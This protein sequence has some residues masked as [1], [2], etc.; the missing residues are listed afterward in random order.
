[1]GN[2]TD[3]F[4]DKPRVRIL[5]A[6]VQLDGMEFTRADLAEEAGLSKSSAN[7]AFEGL[8]QLDLVDQVVESKH[9]VF[10]PRSDSGLFRILSHL[11]AATGLALRNPRSGPVEQD[12]AHAL[13]DRFREAFAPPTTHG[14]SNAGRHTLRIKVTDRLHTDDQTTSSEATRIFHRW[15][16]LE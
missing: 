4:G 14:W 12:A 10:T 9:P 6:L 7:R 13:R 5:E 3:V 1:M 15:S 2:L 8:R 16:R 11:D